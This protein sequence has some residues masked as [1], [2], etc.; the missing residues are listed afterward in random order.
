MY[1]VSA[2][3]AHVSAIPNHQTGR[4]ESLKTRGVVAMAGTFGYEL[5]LTKLSDEEKVEV[6]ALNGIFERYYDLIQTGLYYRLTT[7][8]YCAVWEMAAEDGSEALVSAVYH[9]AHSAPAPVNVSVRGLIPEARYRV[10]IVD[11]RAEE[12]LIGVRLPGAVVLKIEDGFELSGA[13][14]AA[15][16]LTIPRCFTDGQAWQIY[17]HRV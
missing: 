15:G 6:R 3:G 16:G 9:Y 13:A 7:P 5:D 14:L 4:T 1:P 11:K 2:V 8:D 12:G 10:E 17:I